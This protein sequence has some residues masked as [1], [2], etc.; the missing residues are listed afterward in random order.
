MS[1]ALFVI[2]LRY[3]A[4]SCRPATDLC[5]TCLDRNRHSA[6]LVPNC[7][8]SPVVELFTTG[9]LLWK[10][11]DRTCQVLEMWFLQWKFYGRT[12]L[13][14]GNAVSAVKVLWS[15]TVNAWKCGFCYESCC[16][17]WWSLL[18]S[19]ILRSRADS[20]RSYVILH[21]WMD[22]YSAFLNILGSALW[23]FYNR[24]LFYD[25]TLSTFGNVVSAVNVLWSNRR[26]LEMWFLQWIRY[27]RTLLTLGFCS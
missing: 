8:E 20:L 3:F 26:R 14:T 9:F 11:Y 18:Y 21:E 22:F 23:S 1:A 13:T 12:T 6:F 16:C 25:Q 19:A 2:E 7:I 5:R 27:D 15:N 17:C 10:F 24:T 4:L